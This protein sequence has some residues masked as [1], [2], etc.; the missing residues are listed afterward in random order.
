VPVAAV[1]VGKA[2]GLG[3]EDQVDGL[4]S[5]K[6]DSNEAEACYVVRP[7]HFSHDLN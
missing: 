5:G 3:G 1:P 4:E 6:T 2:E 7:F